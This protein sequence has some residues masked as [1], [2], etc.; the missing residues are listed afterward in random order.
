MGSLNE[1]ASE[2]EVIWSKAYPWFDRIVERRG[3]RIGAELGVGFGGHVESLLTIPSIER[4][5]GV[6]PFEHRPDYQDPMNLLQ[7]QFDELYRFVLERTTGYG[8][9]YVHARKR[10]LDAAEEVQEPLDFIYIDADHSFEGVWSDLCAWFTKIRDGGVIGG[11]DYGHLNFPGI[12][13][14]VDRFFGRFGWK[15]HVEQEGVWWVEVRPLGVSYVVPCYNSEETISESIRSIVDGNL[16]PGDEIIAVDDGSDDATSE[17]LEALASETQVMRV[18]THSANRGG[19]AARNTGVENAAQA[20]I[21]CLDADNLLLRGSVGP[22][23]QHLLQH[24]ADAAAFQ[25]IRFFTG[26]QHEITHSW[27]MRGGPVGLADQLSTYKVPGA[28]GNYLYTKNSWARAGGYPESARSLDTWGFALRQLAAGMQMEVM[29]GSAY[30]HRHGHVSYWV[31]ESKAGP[32]SLTAL[33]L[34]IP[35]LDLLRGHDRRYL[36]SRRGRATWFDRLEQRPLR[37]R[38]ERSPG[39]LDAALRRLWRL[40]RAARASLVRMLSRK[41][42]R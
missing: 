23:K 26:D 37:L 20:L 3:L 34:M 4:L 11:H 31:R 17:L 1:M 22:L 19:A 28:S 14:A 5:Y 18:H 29:E 7:E 39:P 25:E 12:Q 2:A 41:G 10:S 8:D 32:L 40:A 21:F 36:L 42:P 9:R 30:L 27:M 16:E 15:I 24:G 33:Q 38:P 6:D 35:Y 13:E